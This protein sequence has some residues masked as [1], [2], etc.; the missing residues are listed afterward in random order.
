MTQ[1]EFERAYAD[2]SGV[3][4]EWLREHRTARPCE[5]HEDTCEGW[6]MLSLERAADFDAREAT[7]HN[8]LRWSYA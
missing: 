3:T 2:R 8:S 4:V 1:D 7:G 6:Q 5:C